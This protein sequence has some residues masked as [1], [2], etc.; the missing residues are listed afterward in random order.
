MEGLEVCANSFS[1]ALAAEHG[2]AIRVELCENLAEGGTTP[3]FATILLTKNRLHIAVWP[4]IRPRGG[5]FLYSDDEFELMKIDIQNCKELG[6]DGVV[7]GILS[8]D[9]EIDKER[10]RI[11]IDLA[12]PMP[13]SFHRAFDMCNDLEKG[14]AD[15]ITLGFVRVL[16]SGGEKNAF[17]GME[18]I[19]R[20]VGLANYKIEIMPGAG[21]T[22]ENIAQ[23]KARTGAKVFHASAS[24]KMGSKMT[25]RNQVAKMGSIDDEYAFVQTSSAVVNQIVLALTS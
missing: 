24:A 11:L 15:L 12:Y 4:I 16:T 25:Y 14:L 8:S 22:S 1:S 20:L 21:I 17:N 19:S 10:C 13:V 7:F 6:C 2:G 23:I 9:G 5:D 18:M 3:S